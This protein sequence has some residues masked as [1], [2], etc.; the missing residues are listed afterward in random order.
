[1]ACADQHTLIREG[2]TAR[3]RGL[4]ALSPEFSRVDERSV[5]DLVL[6][7]KRY[8]SFIRYF[9]NENQH[10]GHW[11]ALMEQD[12]SVAWASLIALDGHAINRYQKHLFKKIDLAHRDGDRDEAK[13][14]FK[15]LYDLLYGLVKTLDRQATFLSG[16]GEQG[17][18]VRDVLV[19]KIAPAFRK[20]RHLKNENPSLF[21]N[22]GQTDPEAPVDVVDANS[23]LELAFID[24]A[25]EA[26]PVQPPATTIL[27]KI[28]YLAHHNVFAGQ[29][30]T[31]LGGVSLAAKNAASGFDKSLAE[32]SGHDP[33]YAL[34]LA[35]LKLFGHAQDSLNQ[36][37]KRHL[38]FYYKEV[39]R[40]QNKK[41]QPDTAF[42]TFELQKAIGQHKLDKGTLFKGGKDSA[43]K[44]RHYALQEDVVLHKAKASLLQAEQLREG[45]LLVAPVANS[46]DG[47]GE[48]IATPDKSWPAFGD[49][50]LAPTHE[51]GFA[52]ASP[53]LFLNEGNRTITLLF[54]F[55]SALPAPPSSRL[56]E[57]VGLPFTV[58]LTGA[59]GWWEQDVEVSYAVGASQLEL[60]AT[61]EVGDP[62]IVPYSE[63]VHELGFGT[64]LPLLLAY[65][66]Q[67]D[68]AITYQ[69]LMDTPL[70]SLEVNVDAKGVKDLALSNDSGT[71]DS[72]K[73]FKPFGDFP[74]Q[75]TNFNIGSKEIFQKK[76]TRLDINGLVAPPVSFEYLHG[77]E[78]SS[79]SAIKES[80]SKRYR[81]TFSTA[82]ALKTA[83]AD[84]TAVNHLGVQSH[85]GF[86]RMKLQ[87]STYSLDTHIKNINNSLNQILLKVADA[88]GDE[89]PANP[90]KKALVQPEGENNPEKSAVVYD[91]GPVK[92]KYNIMENWS[93]DMYA[94]I[95]Q[96]V[97]FKSLIKVDGVNIPTPKE[98][99]LDSFSVDYA[100][101]DTILF[102]SNGQSNAFYHL[103][104]LGYAL[105]GEAGASM[106][107]TIGHTGALY[108]GLDG[109]NA[110]T[111]LTLLF[112]IAEG[113]ANPLKVSGELEWHYLDND[114][115]WQGFGESD[116][117]D[118]TKNFSR[119]GI[120]T[121]SLPPDAGDAATRM[122]GGLR[123]IKVSTQADTDTVCRVISVHAQAGS[124]RL[125]QD[126]GVVFREQLLPGTISKLV[127]ADGAVKQVAQP[128]ASFGGKP[129]ES[130]ERFY[131]R[132]S[133][134]LRHKQRAVTIWDFE[135]LVL[136]QFPE[137][138]KVK[139][140]NHAGFYEAAGKQVFCE[141]LPGHVTVIPTPLL[142]STAHGD[143]LK[144]YAPLNLLVDIQEYLDKLKDPFV[145]VHVRNPQFEEIKLEFDVKFHAQL[146]EL[147]YA[148]QLNI[149]IEQF[150]CPWAY[151]A[152][153]QFSYAGKISKSALINFID[154]RPYVDYL[155]KFKLHHLIRDE[156]G[157]VRQ[158]RADVEEARG[159]SSR[160]V[161]VSHS[162]Q[163]GEQTIRHEIKVIQ[164]NE[165]V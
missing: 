96:D 108:V 154:E 66:R 41:A 46:A 117:M 39:L 32:Y 36:F 50:M 161:L 87:D 89:S 141:H 30:S 165:Q 24:D 159:S 33:H 122:Q 146:D 47:H 134:R 152:E 91:S 101:K 150:L 132:V 82:N 97:V 102:P 131:T 63:K 11:Q 136:E 35:F 85:E 105:A 128:I 45:R 9:N 57:L 151:D 125:V 70:V 95:S 163:D 68:S 110:P 29:V 15:Y 153:A 43:G 80:A 93:I 23:G 54:K 90:Q 144:P 139:C 98:I 10:D 1:M 42:L 103:H 129:E 92:M 124:V 160:S 158:T 142:G 156:N 130:D 113:S 22:A 17:Q 127:Q 140:I 73:P 6:F 37:G 19:G 104:P 2:L 147:F 116:V 14:Q 74:K 56:G 12:A 149:D 79:V 77:G 25:D 20:L 88:K 59:D 126:G 100:A 118:G 72:A 135:H 99:V 5:S 145:T 78:W 38:D 164:N 58:R 65:F 123:W 18:L 61:L 114:N 44:E 3:T 119:S 162:Q 4:E 64:H 157:Q 143:P 51:S 106:L 62:A 48:P 8:A 60:T 52:L 107:P 27:N 115:R 76:L 75:G 71:I 111:T 21:A 49:I 120:V 16:Y 67:A 83:K 69:Q 138:Y 121:L 109:A 7:A 155:S 133:E 94:Q 148:N 13:K 26:L 86:L 31:L 84:F 28:H 81:A 40:L 55:A 53:M 137:V 34:F 112:E